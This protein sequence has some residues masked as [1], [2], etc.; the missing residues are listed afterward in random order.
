MFLQCETNSRS[1]RPPASSYSQRSVTYQTWCRDCKEEDENRLQQEMEIGEAEGN[2]VPTDKKR[3]E[4]PRGKREEVAL[5]TYIGESSRSTYER[6]FE[7]QKDA[8]DLKTTSHNLKHILEKHPGSGPDE[9]R[10]DMKVLRTH[11]SPFERQI[12]ESAVIQTMR[13]KHHLL[14]SRSEYNR[15]ALPRLGIQLVR[16]S[17]RRGKMKN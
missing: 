11:Q 10:F 9:V 8:R 5:Y 4:N 13:D 14:N 6:G 3:K 7:H 15:C 12:Y 2:F 1:E 16:K 17:S